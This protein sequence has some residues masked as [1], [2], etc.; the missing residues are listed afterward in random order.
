MSTCCGS[1]GRPLEE[2][3]LG[4]TL[5]I[6]GDFDSQESGSGYYRPWASL[7]KGGAGGDFSQPASLNQAGQS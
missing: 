5:S 7:S 6:E 2:E 3:H 4:S 1:H